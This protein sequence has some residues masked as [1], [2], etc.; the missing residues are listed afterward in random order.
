L[1][2]TQAEQRAQGAK[3]DKKEAEECYEFLK[4]VRDVSSS[5]CYVSFTVLTSAVERRSPGG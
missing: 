4:E 2:L 1:F 3:K 5:T